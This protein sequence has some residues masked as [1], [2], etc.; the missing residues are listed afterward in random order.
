MNGMERGVLTQKGLAPSVSE[1]WN[2][3]PTMVLITPS[4]TLGNPFMTLSKVRG[5]GGV[6]VAVSVVGLVS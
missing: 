6:F 3:S 4:N 1:M 5:V 2:F